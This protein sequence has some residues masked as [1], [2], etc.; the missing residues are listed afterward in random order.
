MFFGSSLK[1]PLLQFFSFHYDIIQIA[2]TII[3][4]SGMSIKSSSSELP[5]RRVM[6]GVCRSTG[7]EFS[8]ETRVKGSNSFLEWVRNNEGVLSLFQISLKDIDRMVYIPDDKNCQITAKNG[9]VQIHTTSS[10]NQKLPTIIHRET[11]IP[12]I[13]PSLK[14]ILPEIHHIVKNN[15][16][17]GFLGSLFADVSA[18]QNKLGFT[19]RLSIYGLVDVKT[20]EL[21]HKIP[22]ATSLKN[23]GGKPFLV[24]H[25]DMP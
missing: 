21:Q 15:L 23:T 25:L 10:F 11:K 22:I 3:E 16:K 17:V 18:R 2:N 1:N 7:K 6:T 12:D 8:V 14:A 20:G 5:Q 4:R 19:Y 24:V 13:L 9:R